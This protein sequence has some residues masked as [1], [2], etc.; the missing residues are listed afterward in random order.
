MVIKREDEA[1]DLAVP[2][3]L[4][5]YRCL[6]TVEWPSPARDSTIGKICYF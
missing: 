1:D 6:H 5:L 3:G 4:G 2:A